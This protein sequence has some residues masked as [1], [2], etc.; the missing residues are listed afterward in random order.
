MWRDNDRLSWRKL[1][2]LIG[3]LPAESATATAMRLAAPDEGEAP[4]HD[5]DTE[6]WSRAEHLMAAMIDELLRL[7][8]LTQAVHSAKQP[9]WSPEPVPRPGLP[10]VQAKPG[11]SLEAA[12][13]LFSFLNPE[14]G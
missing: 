11:I 6:Q 12:E 2:V 9:S 8:W 3:Q 5:P 7:R 13:T 14:G 4:E 1:G 10:K